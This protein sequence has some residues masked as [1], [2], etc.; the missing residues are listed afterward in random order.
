MGQVGDVQPTAGKFSRRS[1]PLRGTR[2]HRQPH[3]ALRAG[4]ASHH[5]QIPLGRR[6]AAPLTI[7][8]SY[9]PAMPRHHRIAVIPGDGIGHEVVPAG[10]AVLDAV[11]REARLRARLAVLRLELRAL[12]AHRRDDARG[13]PR[14]AARRSTRSSSAPS[15]SRACPTTSRSGDCCSRSAA[16]FSSTSTC[17]RCGC[18]RGVAVAA[19]RPRAGQHRLHDRARE[20]RGRILVDRRSHRR[21]YERGRSA[22]D[23]RLHAQA[24]ATASCATRSSSRARDAST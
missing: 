3:D 23:R 18:C 1:F 21:R 17:A 12:R 10:Q 14:P 16:A 4:D 24:A 2:L 20:H 5:S 7:V 9:T 6:D 11:A 15:D 13:R 19:A 8:R 22:P